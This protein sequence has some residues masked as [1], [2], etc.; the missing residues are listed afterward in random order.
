MEGQSE[1]VID[2][3]QPD[4]HINMY[5]SLDSSEPT[6]WII[7]PQSANHFGSWFCHLQHYFAS[8]ICRHVG[9]V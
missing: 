4:M 5:T 6:I 7:P 9:G 1:T 8:F 2:A 3:Y